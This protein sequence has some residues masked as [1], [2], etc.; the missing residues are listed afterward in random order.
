MKKYKIGDLVTLSA[1]GISL[2]QNHHAVGGWGV[3]IELKDGNC[4]F[5]I[6]CAW[7][8]GRQQPRPIITI[9]FKPYELKFFKKSS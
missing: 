4:V 6:R 9:S 7:S 5:P 2:H 3:V 8:G 1:Q